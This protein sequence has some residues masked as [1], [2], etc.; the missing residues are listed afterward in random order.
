[1]GRTAFVLL[2]VLLGV[3]NGWL[4]IRVIRLLLRADVP[5]LILLSD[6][7]S[8]DSMLHPTEIAFEAIKTVRVLRPGSDEIGNELH[9]ELHPRTENGQRRWRSHTVSLTLLSATS[10]DIASA[11]E[12]RVAAFQAKSANPSFKRTPDGAAKVKS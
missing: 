7:I 11:V 6:R 2:I 10:S 8:F 3:F 12:S 1:M 5:A 9:I 4:L